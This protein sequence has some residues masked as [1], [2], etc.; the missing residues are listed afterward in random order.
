[1]KTVKNVDE[2]IKALRESKDREEIVF[3]DV[4]TPIKVT[5]I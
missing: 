3:D 4:K 2:F 5:K 1:M